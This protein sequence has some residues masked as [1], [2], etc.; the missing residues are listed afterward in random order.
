MGMDEPFSIAA[1]RSEK[2]MTLGQL[3]DYLD[4]KSKGHVSRIEQ[5]EA[6]SVAVALKIEKLSDGRISAASLSKDIALIEEA[7][8][9]H[10]D[11]P[12]TRTSRSLSGGNGTD[13]ADQ[14]TS[15]SCGLSLPHE[16]RAGVPNLT[17]GAAT[18]FDDLTRVEAQ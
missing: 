7:W 15:D 14:E 3:A 10:H 16:R 9:L 6:C 12:N 2:G 5:G 18:F 13:L 8:G 4:L 11:A 1:L 17:T